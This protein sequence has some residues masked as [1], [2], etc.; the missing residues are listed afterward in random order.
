VE[1]DEVSFDELG[2]DELGFNEL[3]LF[4]KTVY[5]TRGGKL[6]RDPI[7]KEWRTLKKMQFLTVFN[8]CG[9]H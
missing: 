3:R 7:G 8:R 4:Q 1:F 2:F 6:Q 5:C 9:E